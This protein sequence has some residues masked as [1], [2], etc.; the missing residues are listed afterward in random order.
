MKPF[1]PAPGAYSTYCEPYAGS[2]A[3]LLKLPPAGREVANDL[4]PALMTFWRVIQ[5]PRTLAEFL[6]IA[7]AAQVGEELF[8]NSLALL[9]AGGGADPVRQA[10]ALFATS[11]LSMSGRLRNY[12]PAG[13][14]G[15]LRRGMDERLSSWL[16][17]LD[18]L[19]AVSARL[20][21]VELTCKPA[22]DVIRET[23]GEGVLFLLDP[24]YVPSTR[25]SREVYRCEM[26]DADHRELLTV[27]KGCKAKVALCGYGN[28]LYDAEL[29]GWTRHAYEVPNDGASGRT[30]RTMTEV[31]WCN[32]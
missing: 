18:R 24:P 19:P 22:L 11:R 29:A 2:G 15:R 23:D 3:V 7:Q 16:S 17:A 28:P 5:D 20:R 12:A 31:V 25:T 26:A 8:R 9:D 6:G 1:L 14:T 30:K 32:S 13:K 4:H 21:G 27:V 10:L